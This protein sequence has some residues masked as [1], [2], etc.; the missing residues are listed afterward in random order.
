MFNKKDEKQKVLKDLITL[1]RYT[2]NVFSTYEL[3]G[4]VIIQSKTSEKAF[5]NIS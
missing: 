3:R 4:R 5:K 2:E 1:Y